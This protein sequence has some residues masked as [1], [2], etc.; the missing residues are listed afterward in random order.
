MFQIMKLAK[1]EEDFVTIIKSEIPTLRFLL[2]DRYPF[3]GTTR[4]TKPLN[5]SR[6]ALRAACIDRTVLWMSNW[7]ECR[8]LAG[9]VT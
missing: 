1:H 6:L 3:H 9:I 7:G 4:S 2:R 5:I 8:V